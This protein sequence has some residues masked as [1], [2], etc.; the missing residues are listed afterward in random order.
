MPEGLNDG[1]VTVVIP[2]GYEKPE[3]T[4]QKRG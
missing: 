3:K 2:E 4:Q 1:S